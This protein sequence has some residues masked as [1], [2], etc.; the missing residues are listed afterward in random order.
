MPVCFHLRVQTSQLWH[1]FPLIILNPTNTLLENA[2]L[3]SI[4]KHQYRDLCISSIW[5]ISHAKQVNSQQSK[6]LRT[7][8]ARAAPVGDHG[9][10][11]QILVAGKDIWRAA[12]LFVLRGQILQV[13]LHV[14][15]LPLVAIRQSHVMGQQR[16]FKLIFSEHRRVFQKFRHVCWL[17]QGTIAGW[18]WFLLWDQW[19]S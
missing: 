18:D 13:Q 6:L 9:G 5:F 19:P 17:E 14:N 2:R 3:D 12:A 7:H 11:R 8:P 15:I 10:W 1:L 16:T 4:N